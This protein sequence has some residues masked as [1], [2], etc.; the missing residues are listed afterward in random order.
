MRLRSYIP[1]AGPLLWTSLP[2]APVVRVVPGFTPQWYRERLGVDFSE[3][4]HVSPESRYADL[5][6]M[7]AYLLDLFPTTP[8]CKAVEPEEERACCAT[9]SGVY[10]ILP[11]PLLYGRKPRYAANNWPDMDSGQR[12]TKEEIGALPPVDLDNHPAAQAYF[13]QMETIRRRWGTVAGHPNVQG[14]LNVALKL[15]GPDIFV[16]MVEDPPFVHFFLQHITQTILQFTQRVQAKQRESGFVAEHMVS[17]NCVVNMISP[18]MYRTFVLPCDR[19]L[20]ESFALFGIHTCNWNSTPYLEAMAS[21]PDMQY[22]DMGLST[23]LPRAAALFPSDMTAG[24]FFPPNEVAERSEEWLRGE[25]RRVTALFS[26]C[27]LIVADIDSDFPDEA[28]R[29]FIRLVEEETGAPS[30]C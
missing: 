21:L 10:G 30:T 8:V 23:D 22:L 7:R 5:A 26:C 2:E 27:D 9:L 4:W 20:A 6:R 12:L 24:V 25:I 14:A 29:R 16:D 18:A 13:E 28:L 3:R 11:I 17:S 15:R 19:Q 1:L